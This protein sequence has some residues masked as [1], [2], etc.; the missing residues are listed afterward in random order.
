MN[1]TAVPEEAFASGLLNKEYHERLILDLE[2]LALLAGVPPHVVWSRMSAFCNEDEVEWT[3]GV[4][5]SPCAGL[6]FVG[7]GHTPSVA[8]KMLAMTGVFLRNYTD[9]RVMPVQDVLRLIKADDMPTC[10]VLLIPN[11]CMEKDNGGD[12]ASWE[13][14]S[15]MG[16]LLTR[17]NLGL[18]T[19]L[20]VTNMT[21]LEKQYGSTMREHIEDKFAIS[22]PNDFKPYK[23]S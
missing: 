3:R 14:S 5:S 10:T 16:L 8:D 12:I 13:V 19:I 18:K 23:H 21:T 9:A 17:S 15:L 1:L 4:R 7:K 22:K 6:A 2:K 20:Y 11:F